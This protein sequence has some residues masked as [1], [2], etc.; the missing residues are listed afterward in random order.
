MSNSLRDFVYG[1]SLGN[2]RNVGLSNSNDKAYCLGGKSGHPVTEAKA[3][4]ASAVGVECV[5]AFCF[6]DTFVHNARIRCSD[7]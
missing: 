6:S 1:T 7:L 5:F 2:I 3:I 4:K